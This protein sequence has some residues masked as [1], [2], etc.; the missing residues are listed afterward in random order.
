MRWL[1]LYLAF[2]TCRV[3]VSPGEIVVATKLGGCLVTRA[4]RPKLYCQR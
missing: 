2:T 4:D 3:W 1:L